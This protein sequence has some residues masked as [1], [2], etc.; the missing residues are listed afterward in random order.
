MTGKGPSPSSTSP[1]ITAAAVSAMATRSRKH[2]KNSSA[3]SCRSVARLSSAATCLV[4]S[5]CQ[6]STTCISAVKKSAENA[7]WLP[8]LAKTT[9]YVSVTGGALTWA[10]RTHFSLLLSCS[11]KLAVPAS[12]STCNKKLSRMD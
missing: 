4:A 2:Q 7:M 10:R 9:R 3:R 5:T 12:Q 6:N 11:F 8:L 1:Y